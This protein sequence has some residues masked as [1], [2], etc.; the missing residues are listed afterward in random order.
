MVSL[1]Q[2]HAKMRSDAS[3][4]LSPQTEA[5]L[6]FTPRETMQRGIAAGPSR[7]SRPTREQT[8]SADSAVS[9]GAALSLDAA[10]RAT[11]ATTV[12]VEQSREFLFAP[13]PSPRLARPR[14]DEK[15]WYVAP[16]GRNPFKTA[17]PL[18]NVERDS[19][20]RSLGSDV[21]DLAMRRGQTTSERDARAK[22]AMLKMRLTGRVLLVPPDNSGGLITSS[23]PFPLLGARPPSATRTRASHADDGNRT[24][25][26]RLRQQADSL[27]R[28]RADS[29]PQ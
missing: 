29:L 10:Q 1:R 2:P 19:V 6:F 18:T 12:S 20:L 11:A 24:R 14:R 23:L 28:S 27:R 17:D 26:E 7:P 8:R 3:A 9:V 16:R 5:V 22:E 4:A 15:P 25:L 21:P 13:S